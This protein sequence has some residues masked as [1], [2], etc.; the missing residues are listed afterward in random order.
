MIGTP[1]HWKH[2][3]NQGPPL[4]S[5]G[6]ISHCLVLHLTLVCAV[7]S[8]QTFPYARLKLACISWSFGLINPAKHFVVLVLIITCYCSV[9]KSAPTF[10]FF[11]FVKGSVSCGLLR[12]RIVC[13]S[14]RS[15]AGWE[16][17]FG[18]RERA[19]RCLLRRGQSPKAGSFLLCVSSAI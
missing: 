8:V 6:L 2:V 10:F 19:G 14:E 7:L 18:G 3:S 15:S 4:S 12:R 9:F 13:S 16:S 1:H 17:C 5:A 11:F